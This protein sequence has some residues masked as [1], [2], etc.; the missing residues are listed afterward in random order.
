MFVAVEL[1][2]TLA[3]FQ[4]GSLLPVM[5]AAMYYMP[6]LLTCISHSDLCGKS[7]VCQCGVAAVWQCGKDASV[8]VWQ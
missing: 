8:A 1:V 7:A 3:V 4:C 5:F 6:R 2:S